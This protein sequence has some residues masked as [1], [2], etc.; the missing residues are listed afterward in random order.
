MTYWSISTI[1][2]LQAHG[3]LLVEIQPA[4]LQPLRNM[5]KLSDVRWILIS[6]GQR[7][8]DIPFSVQNFWSLIFR[9][10][11][12]SPGVK[13]IQKRHFNQDKKK[14]S[15]LHH[16]KCNKCHCKGKCKKESETGRNEMQLWDRH[17][18]W[19]LNGKNTLYWKKRKGYVTHYYEIWWK[20]SICLY[21]RRKKRKQQNSGYINASAKKDTQIKDKWIFIQK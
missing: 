5:T 6:K 14:T 15:C 16:F 9:K 4:T 20:H 13:M 17:G 21:F 10:T 7:V 12:D 19:H 1:H 8:Q 2:F 18:E 3:S 11:S